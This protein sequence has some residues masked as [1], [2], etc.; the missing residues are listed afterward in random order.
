MTYPV[1]PSETR[2]ITVHGASMM[3]NNKEW[4]GFHY[5]TGPIMTAW[6]IDSA[7]ITDQDIIQVTF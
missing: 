7:A 5:Q 4:Q 6:Y 3:Q 1:Q 2:Q